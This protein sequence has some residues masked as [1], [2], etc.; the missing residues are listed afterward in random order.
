MVIHAWVLFRLAAEVK[1]STSALPDWLR[2][3][4][5]PANELLKPVV[6]IVNGAGLKFWMPLAV[7]A[8]VH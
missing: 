3:K 8:T 1:F 6:S 2:L 7:V 5:P 4:T